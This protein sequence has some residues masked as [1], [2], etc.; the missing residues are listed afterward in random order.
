M[1]FILGQSTFIGGFGRGIIS[2][3][4][5]TNPQIQDI[6]HIGFTDPYAS[7][8]ISQDQVT[9]V[10]YAPGPTHN[11]TPT[12]G[13]VDANS[14]SLTIAATAAG[15]QSGIY[16]SDDYFVTTYSYTKEQLSPGQ[17]TWAMASRPEKESATYVMTRGKARGQS[18]IGQT[19]VVF[20]SVTTSGIN[21]SVAAG[22]PGIGNLDEITYGTVSY[23]GGGTGIFAPFAGQA[24]VQI[25]YVPLPTV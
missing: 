23:I 2:V 18:T 11:V 8:V 17:E 13:C 7:E 5:S 12:T 16:I 6:F 21:I 4:F 14:I 1:A 19:G 25:P 10:K 9:I 15:G 22:Y 3:Q 20:D 24:S